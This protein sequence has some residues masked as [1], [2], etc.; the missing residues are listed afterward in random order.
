VNS[1]FAVAIILHLLFSVWIYSNSV[2][3]EKNPMPAVF[4]WITLVLPG[5]GKLDYEAS[6]AP[7]FLACV[8]LALFLL[9][10]SKALPG[11]RETLNQLCRKWGDDAPVTSELALFTEEYYRIMPEGYALPEHDKLSGWR[12]DEEKRLRF[13]VAPDGRTLKTWEVIRENGLH[14]YW[15][16]AHPKYRE[17][18]MALDERVDMAEPR[19]RSESG[20]SSDAGSESGSEVESRNSHVSREDDMIV[21]S[22]ET[23]EEDPASYPNPT[24]GQ[25]RWGELLSL[26]EGVGALLVGFIVPFCA[27]RSPALI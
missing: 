27:G 6:R 8:S 9:L 11:I 12:Y 2:L 26:R 20:C 5:G 7:F 13:K 10:P 14:T 16:G 18:T 23:W 3:S 15:R 24:S 17:A 4:D 22:A 19:D 1:Y 21:M 25:R